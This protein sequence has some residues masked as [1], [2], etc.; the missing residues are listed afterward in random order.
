MGTEREAEAAGRSR[1]TPADREGGDSAK[2]GPAGMAWA[3]MSSFRNLPLSPPAAQLLSST[4][5]TLSSPSP[6][7]PHTQSITPPLTRRLEL[8]PGVSPS[9]LWPLVS[10]PRAMAKLPGQKA[11]LECLTLG[12]G[13][14]KHALVS[15]K[16]GSVRA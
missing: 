16:H 9:Q 10:K 1:R 2:A 6:D 11:G 5:L 13:G 15:T 4:A 3:G 14:S 7:P 8:G 12:R